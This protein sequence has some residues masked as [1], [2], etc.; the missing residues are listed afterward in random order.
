LAEGAPD[1]LAPPPGV[2]RGRREPVDVE[3][4]YLDEIVDLVGG[5]DAIPAQRIVVDYA[6]GAGLCEGPAAFARFPAL[7]VV[8]LFDVLDGTFPNHEANPLVESN[9]DALRERVVAEGASLGLAFDGDADRCAFVDRDGRTVGADI[10]TSILVPALLRRKPG[11]GVIYDLRSSRV[12]PET[13]VE[14]GGRP[15]RE[16]VGHSFMKETMKREGAIG[17]GELSG[18]FYFAE[19]H[20]S[21]N[22]LLAGLMVLAEL[23]RSGKDLATAADE[24]RIYFQSGEINFRVEDKDGA[25]ARIAE[26]FAG[27]EIDRLDGIMVQYPDWWV[28]VRPSNTEPFLRLVMEAESPDLLAEKRKVLIDMLGEPATGGH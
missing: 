14:N 20:N 28:N 23:G 27:G 15:L 12:V 19:Y 22:G 5:P 8:P 6:N 21:D 25:L 7:E 9:L 13:I 3:K 1:A 10:V 11:A 2:E 26:T 16:R 24:K 17:G 4:S 18:H